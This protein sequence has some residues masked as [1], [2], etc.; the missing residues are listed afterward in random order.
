MPVPQLDTL[1]VKQ[2][3]ELRGLV[4][5]AMAAVEA[6]EKAELLAKMEEMAAEHGLTLD[7]VFAEPEAPAVET[8]NACGVAAKH[9]GTVAANGTEA[10]PAGSAGP[11]PNGAAHSPAKSPAPKLNGAKKGKKGS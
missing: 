2:L 9:A 11:A 4:E 6:R 5:Q 1:S 10:K 8:G 3:R 7:E